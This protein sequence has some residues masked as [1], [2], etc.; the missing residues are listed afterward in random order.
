MEI[1]LAHTPKKAKPSTAARLNAAVKGGSESNAQRPGQAPRR[2][3]GWEISSDYG[4]PIRTHAE[5]GQVK[6]SD[7]ARPSA[8]EKG[9]PEVTPDCYST[10]RPC[11]KEAKR[12]DHAECSGKRA[13]L[14]YNIK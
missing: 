2:R 3:G 7:Q 13:P 12:S 11:A 6:Y 10:T 1:Y 5:E 8:A 9:G 4:N 14:D